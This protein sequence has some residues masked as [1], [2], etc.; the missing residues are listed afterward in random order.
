MWIPYEDVVVVVTNDPVAE[1]DISNC[2]LVNLYDALRCSRDEQFKPLTDLLMELN[3]DKYEPDEL[4]SVG[5]GEIRDAL[6]AIDP[7]G[8]DLIRAPEHLIFFILSFTYKYI[9]RC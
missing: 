5:F 1:G 4:S 6:L 3:P 2:E 7:L 8:M 9:N